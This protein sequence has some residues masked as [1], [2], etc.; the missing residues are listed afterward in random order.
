MFNVE[1]NIYS[2]KSD[3]LMWSGTTASTNPSNINK[4]INEIADVIAEKMRE[5]GFLKGPSK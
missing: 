2:L 1:T 5:E 4:T 3:K